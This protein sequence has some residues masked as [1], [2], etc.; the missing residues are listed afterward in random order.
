MRHADVGF[1]IALNIIP[2]AG[3]QE[4]GKALIRS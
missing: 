4:I 3:L 2:P 1:G